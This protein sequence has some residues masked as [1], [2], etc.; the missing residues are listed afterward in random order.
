MRWALPAYKQTQCLS[1][2]AGQTPHSQVALG[3]ALWRSCTSPALHFKW[4]SRPTIWTLF[5]SCT[6]EHTHAKLYFACPAHEETCLAH[7]TE[8]TTQAIPT[9][10]PARSLAGYPYSPGPRR[11]TRS[12]DPGGTYKR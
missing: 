3:N 10:S 4:R 11:S 5:P 2:L 1:C 8:S 7:A 9:S 6:W 12:L